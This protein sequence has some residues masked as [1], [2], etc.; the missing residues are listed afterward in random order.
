M[1]IKLPLYLFFY[2][3]LGLNDLMTLVMDVARIKIITSSAINNRYINSNSIYCM[4]MS[5]DIGGE[6]E[7]MRGGKRGRGRR[8]GCEKDRVEKG[9]KRLGLKWRRED[10]RRRRRDGGR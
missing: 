6:A 5:R 4:K 7:R 2:M 1:Y 10:K 9:G 8:E 3:A